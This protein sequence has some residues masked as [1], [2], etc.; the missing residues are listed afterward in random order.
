MISWNEGAS[1]YP[2]VEKVE[3]RT[4]RKNVSPAFHIITSEDTIHYLNVD[5]ARFIYD[6]LGKFLNGDPQ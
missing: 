6:A 5:D 2:V 4:E 1:Q 3:I